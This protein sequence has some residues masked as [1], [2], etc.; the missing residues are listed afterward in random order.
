VEKLVD[1][2]VPDGVPGAR[3]LPYL[4]AE[5]AQLSN[6]VGRDVLAWIGQDGQR[7]NPRG[8]RVVHPPQGTDKAERCGDVEQLGSF[9]L[10]LT[11][12]VVPVWALAPKPFQRALSLDFGVQLLGLFAGLPRR[13]PEWNIDE[14]GPL[15]LE[16]GST[17]SEDQAA[18]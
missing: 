14:D 8:R 15:N 16:A 2:A 3:H 4:D 10:D 5:V 17:M 7:A 11:V 12:S 18:Q 1:M 13:E 9:G 6:V